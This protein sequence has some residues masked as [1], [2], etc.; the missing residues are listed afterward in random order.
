[1]HGNSNIK[2]IIYYRLMMHGNSNIK[3]I[4]TI[5]DKIIYAKF[6]PKRVNTRNKTRKHIVTA[7]FGTYLFGTYLF[8]I[9]L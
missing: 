8:V 7:V 2:I 9:L 6:P 1:M 4:S 5:Y 3:Y